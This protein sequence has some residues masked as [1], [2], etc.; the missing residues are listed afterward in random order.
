M[1]DGRSGWVHDPGL[2]S[3][4]YASQRDKGAFHELVGEL[5][6]QWAIVRSVEGEAN[7]IPLAADQAWT[8][9]FLDDISAVYVRTDGPNQALATGGYRLLRHLTAP[10]DVLQL[11]MMRGPR[12]ADLVHD[13]RLSVD[14]DSDSPRAAFL[15]ACGALAARDSASWEQ[16]MSRLRQL[17][18]G[19]PAIA[20]L[21]SAWA[22][23]GGR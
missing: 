12:T 6:L 5:D 23:A 17:A 4:Y 7:A 18:P 13:A 9:V 16:V 11:S 1:V 10:G 14:Q 3:R 2:L 21:L 20:V 8:M 19:H 15:G 22:H